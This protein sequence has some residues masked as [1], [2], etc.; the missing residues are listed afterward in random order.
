MRDAA[1]R[2]V[3]HAEREMAGASDPAARFAIASRWAAAATHLDPRAAGLGSAIKDA[4]ALAEEVRRIAAGPLAV[5]DTSEAFDLLRKARNV[6]FIHD[7]VGELSLDR[8]LITEILKHARRVFSAAAGAPLAGRA[9]SD[10]L[11]RVGLAEVATEIIS[12]GRGEIGLVWEEASPEVKGK[13]E[14][15]DLVIAKGQANVYALHEREKEILKPM[16]CLF[17][18]MCD[19]VAEVFGGKGRLTILKLWK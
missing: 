4:D 5:D 6:L 15:V 14:I 10:D 7:G 3:Q 12:V 1:I 8:L 18:T 13:L 9:T 17:R 16:L 19:P 11:H 2:L